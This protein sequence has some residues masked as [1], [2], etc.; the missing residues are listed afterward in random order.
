VSDRA[1]AVD[2]VS[3]A[4]RIYDERNQSLKAWFLKGRRQ[5]YEEFV[6]LDDI[7]FEIER[8]TTFGLVG[9]NGCGKSTLLKCVAGILTPDAGTIT[10]HG[11]I[12]AL[13]ELGAGFHPEL[14]GRDN[15]FLNGSL[16]GLSTK[17]VERRLD[18]I[19]AFSEIEEAIDRPVKNYSSGMYMRL[20]FSIAI[21]VD[22]EI[23]LVD[24]VLAVGDESFQRKCMAKFGE[25]QAQGCTVVVVSHALDTMRLLCDQAAYVDHGKLM[26]VGHAGDMIDLYL[27]RDGSSITR[28]TAD[29]ARWGSGEALITKAALL[30]AGG[31]R[32]GAV[33]TGD[34]IRVRLGY[35][36]HEPVSNASFG[37]MIHTPIGTTLAMP[38]SD[39]Q[40]RGARLD[41]Y[42]EIDVVLDALPLEPG[43]Y[44]LTVFVQAS[45]R[46]HAFDVRY[47]FLEFDVDPGGSSESN[48]VLVID[49]DWEPP[50]PGGHADA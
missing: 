9:H 47:R 25:L 39:V 7:S 3:K 34:R 33:R 2:A 46:Q 26:G 4:Y 35:L 32:L 16:L 24:E 22:P 43:T 44:T 36:T 14:T 1:V 21:A 15:I 40:H 48:G 31:A 37:V 8:G 49:A 19:V 38:T 11:K 13:I 41:G 50:V 30:A 10:T 18:D 17:E 45:D 12:S 42:G 29:Q 27:G 23:L 6:A 28:P 5:R 20:G